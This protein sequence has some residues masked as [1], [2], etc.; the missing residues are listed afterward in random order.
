MVS[1]QGQP[2]DTK[3]LTLTAGQE[4]ISA[5]VPCDRGHCQKIK[6]PHGILAS[7]LECAQSSVERGDKISSPQGL[8][9]APWSERPLPGEVLTF[10]M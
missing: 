10:Q 4:P 5:G 9:A 6:H 8:E 1:G 3:A 7:S 2:R